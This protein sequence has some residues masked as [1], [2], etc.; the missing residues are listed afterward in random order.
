M[1]PLYVV[2]THRNVGKTTTCIGLI[3]ALRERGLKVGYMKP[4][5]QR[6]TTIHGEVF[7][8]DTLAV[9]H[10]MDLDSS[11]V[12]MA[13][14]LPRG[15]VE[16]EV[17]HLHAD[18]LAEKVRKTFE[19]LQAKHDIVIIEAMGHVAAGS[20]I[21]LSSSEVAQLVGA[22]VLLIS[23]GGIGSTIDDIALCSTF[24]TA[25]GA[26]LMGTVVN[27]V[28]P[29]KYRRVHEATT[30]GLENLGIRSFGT[31]PYEDTLAFPTMQQV[32]DLLKGKVVCGKDALSNRIG[33]V[34]VGAMQPQHMVGY[35]KNRTLVITPGDRSDNILAILSVHALERSAEPPVSGLILSGGFRPTEKVMSLLA[36]AGLS[37]MLCREDTHE[38]ATRLQETVFKIAPDDRDRIGAAVCLVN[39]YV[40]VD[41]I[42]EALA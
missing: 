17:R 7:D 19:L 29:E 28:W 37:V 9:V 26:N 32:V 24:L 36:E 3:G 6:V 38:I 18:V 11:E 2:G 10:G 31:M 27:K 33:K 23:R 41:A 8:D 4:L 15:R 20:C 25:R 34:H 35:L 13:V 30:M 14:P 5:G 1:R 16:A 21:K 42:I 22:R 40:N 39:E 12:P